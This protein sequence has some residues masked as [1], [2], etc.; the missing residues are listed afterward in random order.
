MTATITLVTCALCMCAMAYY[1]Y[2]AV[3]VA[4]DLERF[5]KEALWAVLFGVS[6]MLSC[7]LTMT[8]ALIY[9]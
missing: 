2:R 1:A 7:L 8:M 5:L 4:P 9:I 3:F 6:A